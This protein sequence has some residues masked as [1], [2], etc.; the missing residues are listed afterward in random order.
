MKNH[1]ALRDSSIRAHAEETRGLY[2]Q[3]DAAC[4]SFSRE[5]ALKCPESCGSCCIGF[6]PDIV[7]AEAELIALALIA[8]DHGHARAIAEDGYQV[9]DTCPYYR[10]DNAFHCS[11]YHERPLVCRAFGFGSFSGKEGAQSFRLCKHM[12]GETRSWHGDAIH[13]FHGANPPSIS[14]HADRLLAI[15]PEKSGSRALLPTAVQDATRRILH[16]MDLHSRSGDS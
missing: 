11:I 12:P 4:E 16:R 1:P 9:S 15:A 14:E 3:V 13:A 6:T 8:S 7:P 2:D 10:H 5:S